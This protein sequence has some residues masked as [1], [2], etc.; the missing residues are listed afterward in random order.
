M[1]IYILFVN[2]YFKIL[3]FIINLYLTILLR[4]MAVTKYMWQKWMLQRGA[5][6]ATLLQNT[7]HSLENIYE[8]TLDVLL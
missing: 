7:I 2:I 5:L 6:K 3:I 1:Y 8:D 4:F